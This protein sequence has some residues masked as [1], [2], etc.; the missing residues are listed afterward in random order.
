MRYFCKREKT[1]EKRVLLWMFILL[2]PIHILAEDSGRIQGQV[3]KAGNPVDG[4]DVLLE[5]L[6]LSTIT[7][8]NGIY[9]FNRIPPGKY[10]LTFT[11]GENSL[12]KEDIAVTTST[13]TVCDVDVEWEVLLSHAVT[14]YAAS[15]RTE[16]VVDAPAAVSVVEETE[17]ER[18]SAHGQLPKILETTTGVDSTQSGLYDFNVNS[19]GFNSTFNR[20]VLTL[21]DGAEMSGVAVDYPVWV[22]ISSS[23][24]DLASME[25]IR[26]PGA[27]LYG[28]GAFNG[29]LNMTTKDPRYSQ[30]GMVR[31]SL[32]ELSMGGFDLRYAGKLGKGWYFSVL[33]GYMESKDFSKS[34]NESVEYEGLALE[35]VPLPLEKND[36]LHAKIR[37]DKHFASGSVLTLETWGLDYKG[38]TSLSASGRMQDTRAV[39]PR[40]RVNFRSSHWNI[41][42]YGYTADWEAISLGSG[43]PM[44]TYQYKLHGEVQGFTNFGGERGRIVG[45]FSL[46]LQGNDTADKEG[47]QTFMSGAKDDHMEAAFGQLDYNLTDKLKVVFAGRLDFSTL[48]KAQFSPKVSAVY[49]LNP[50]HS[51]LLSYNRAFQAP[52][53]IQYFLKAP[54]GPPVDRSDIEDGLSNAFGMDLGLGFKSIPMLALGNENLKVE[55]IT[56]YE[57]GYSNIFARKLIF[58]LNYYRSQLKNFV[59]NMLPHVN[60]DYGPYAPPSGLPPEIQNAVLT[61]LE[62]N[63][64]PDLFALMSNSLEDGSAIFAVLSYTNAGRVN[65][66]GIELSLKYFLSKH[67]KFDFNYTW[68]DFVVKEELMEDPILPNSPEHRFNLG[69]AYISDRVDVSM[70]YRWVDDFPWSSGVYRGHVKSYNLV[71]LTANIYVG[72]G[73]SLG[74]NISNLIDA[75][76][77]QIFGGDILRRNIV[78][79]LSY[80]W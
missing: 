72:N 58:N 43:V 63:L 59:T 60:P 25:M 66:Q 49:T 71:D 11:R 65:T 30:G 33:G 1:M 73:F 13:T 2:I 34:R 14:V 78:A 19:R 5:E 22:G 20:R 12:T 41:L 9:F 62:Q 50:G 15:R 29:V 18:E 53:Y 64:S 55:E 38:G 45:G 68:F 23:I 8:K 39:V 4:V 36:R 31:L 3:R 27:A 10:T 54:V 37:L 16:R 61:A 67:W 70:R 74:V 21:L 44:F 51:I 46:R 80:R 7:D 52:S 75:K 6:S 28:A 69:A 42:L 40:A 17:I 35:M 47:I 48:H 32:G 77:Y 76:H 56:S 57:I 26:G 79:A 24:N